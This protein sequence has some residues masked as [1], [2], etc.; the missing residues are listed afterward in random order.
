M[1]RQRAALADPVFLGPGTGLILIFGWLLWAPSV[2]AAEQWH[3]LKFDARHSGNVPDRTVTT[4]LGLV[5]AV[6]LSDAVLTSPVVDQRCIYVVDG[7]GV[8]FCIDRQTHEIIWKTPTPGGLANCNNVSS[9]VIAGPNL[10]F[11]TTAGYYCVLDRRSGNMVRQLDCRDPI[12]SA[13]VVVEDRVY[14]A[15]LGCAGVRGRG[16]WRGGV[17]LGLRERGNRLFG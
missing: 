8:A 15:T 17:D 9:P 1:N 12:L 11:G 10:H 4:P 3:Q 16:Q 5:G 14:F 2:S 6:P 13:P 7:S